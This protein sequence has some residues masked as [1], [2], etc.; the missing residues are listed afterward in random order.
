MKHE[1]CIAA[2]LALIPLNCA[3]AENETPAG[4]KVKLSTSSVQFG[5]ISPCKAH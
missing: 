2:L 5:E 4:P 3:V 1:L